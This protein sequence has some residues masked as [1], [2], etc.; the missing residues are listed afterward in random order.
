MADTGSTRSDRTTE[1][2]TP[3][4][5][6]SE[7]FDLL[8]NE[9]RLS[10]LLA[11]W[12]EQVPL[13]DDNAV[14]FSRI[15]DRVDL[16]D[17]GNVSYH[18]EQLEEQFITQHTERGGYEL[19]IPGLKLVRTIVAGTGV[20]DATLEPTEIDQPCPLCGAPTEIT[21]REGVVF[22]ICNECEGAAPGKADIDG[23]LN[24]FYLEP[25]GLSDWSPEQL[26]AASI[27]TALQQARSLFNGVCP[28]CSGRVDGQLDCCPDHDPTDGCEQCGTLV[29]TFA[30]FQ[31]RVCKFFG[32]PNP[33][34]L[35]LFH[36]AVI[37]FYDDHGISTRV[38]ADDVESARRVYSLIYDHEW[39]RLSEDPP[40]IAVT[41][42]R[43]DE[44]IRLTFDETVSVVDV[45]R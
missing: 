2:R 19:L 8:G 23:A 4:P 3:D 1:A 13:A 27:I 38:Q 11:I 35:P 32:F 6:A 14:P 5:R 37:S 44:E 28:T 22:L 10:I 30:R 17:R 33:G 45:Q 34:W 21:Y 36:P 9:T 15:F 29:G 31:C 20:T 26:Y 39:E 40:R 41:A 42:S 24:G 43:D 25:A 12:E 16:D 7:A 18:L